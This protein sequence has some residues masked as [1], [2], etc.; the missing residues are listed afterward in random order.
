VNP[1]LTIV[2]RPIDG[3]A[4]YVLIGNGGHLL[5][6]DGRDPSIR[7]EDVDRDVLFS[8]QTVNGGTVTQ[9][10]FRTHCQRMD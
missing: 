9:V 8:S 10:E 6:L 2:K 3:D 7:V 5:F 1:H 4:V